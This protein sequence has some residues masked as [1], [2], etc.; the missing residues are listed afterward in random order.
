M[1]DARLIYM[2]AGSLDEARRLAEAVI[3]ERLAACVNIIPGMKS[4]YHWQGRVAE[5]E[6]VVVIAKTR[7][8]LVD[9]LTARVRA[10]H[11]YDCPCV[12]AILIAPGNPDFFDWIAAET[13][14]AEAAN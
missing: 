1:D 12:V 3:G 4:L 6:E 2:T 8:G 10:I 7:A 13:A 5:D 11:S 9:R 14:P